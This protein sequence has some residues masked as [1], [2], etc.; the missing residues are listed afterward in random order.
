MNPK[1]AKKPRQMRGGRR[2]KGDEKLILPS[3]IPGSERASKLGLWYGKYPIPENE[4]FLS[5]ENFA[6]IQDVRR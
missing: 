3:P 4:R 2:P 1:A 6:T 5:R